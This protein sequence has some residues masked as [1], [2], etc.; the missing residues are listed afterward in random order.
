MHIFRGYA[1][2]L[3]PSQHLLNGVDSFMEV[4]GLY[5]LRH[6]LHP[7]Q[8]IALDHLYDV[9]DVMAGLLGILTFQSE[10]CHPV[11]M[12]QGLA[13][14]C[15]PG[16]RVSSRKVAYPLG[17]RLELGVA[18]LVGREDRHQSDRG[19]DLTQ[20]LVYFVA[21]Q[22]RCGISALGIVAMAGRTPLCNKEDIACGVGVDGFVPRAANSSGGGQ[23]GA[24]LRC[25]PGGQND[26]VYVIIQPQAWGPLMKLVGRPELIDDPQYANPEARLDKLDDCFAII[27][28]WTQRH[29][30][31]EVMQR[32]NDLDVPC[33]PILS[34][35][36]LIEDEALRNR[37]MIVDVPHPTR[38][39]FKN[40]SCPMVL[41][42][43]PVEVKSPPLL[44][45]HTE[46]I[47]GEVMGYDKEQIEQ[48]RSEGI[49]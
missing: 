20:D 2:R 14:I 5:G 40:V 34:T 1:D 13:C 23:P 19:P 44:G 15:G 25:S 38:G 49:V 31:W 28:A 43:S 26:Y 33:G 35:K 22:R 3:G 48:L 27:E 18:D 41:S 36:E 32:L 6:L 47:L 8:M 16:V 9:V 45:E 4:P 12:G 11:V 24:A 17:E 21:W 39:S 42:D 46:E 29:S 7:A 37:G 30:K 10:E